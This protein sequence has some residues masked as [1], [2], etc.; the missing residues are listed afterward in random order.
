MN[1]GKHRSHK[2]L[3]EIAPQLQITNYHLQTTNRKLP[4]LILF[5]TSLIMLGLLT[6]LTGVVYPVVVTVLAQ[7]TFPRVANG[8]V[9]ERDGKVV[10]SELIAQPFVGAQYFHGRPSATGG[11]PCNPACGSASNQA[12]SN[13]A[14]Q[15][16]VSE[17]LAALK[18]LD[19]DN[20]LA[21]PSDLLTA[22]ASGLDPH[23]SIAAAEYQLCRVARERSMT[24]EQLRMLI[25]RQA[26]STGF[27]V[28]ERRC[29]N[30]LKLN[31]A[32]DA[33]E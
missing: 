22:S 16:M 23:I 8:S 13:P 28:A 25:E 12:A 26:T 15:Q 3:N 17:R 11:F 27:G 10:G 31:L 1:H 21:V 5:R 6:V 2:T 4:M 24:E 18:A 29:V 9:I 20:P 30:V 14:W 33:K 32:L 19:P 7:V